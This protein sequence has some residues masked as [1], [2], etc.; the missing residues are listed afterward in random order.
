MNQPE[1]RDIHLPDTIAWWPPAPGWWLLAL[2]ILIMVFIIP[3][4]IKRLKSKPL[5]K[6]ALIEF[7]KIELSFQTHQSKTRL[8]QD[9]SVLLRRICLSYKPRREAASLTGPQ[10]IEYLNTM[11]ANKFFSDQLAEILFNAPY[12]KQAEFNAHE[13][14]S[15]CKAWITQLP[16]R[17]KE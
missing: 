3:V 6:L 4:I 15:S 16:R 17:I 2:L 1:L 10:W 9:I 5:N 14:I 12:Q 7:R 11:T 13:L 8:A